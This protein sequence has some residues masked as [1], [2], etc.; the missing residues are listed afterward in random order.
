MVR[1]LAAV[2]AILAGTSFTQ[3]DETPPHPLPQA[4]S[5]NDYWRERPLLDALSH[6]FCSVEADIFLIDGQLLVGHDRD[7]LQPDRT[8]ETLYLQPLLQRMRQHNGRIYPDG[9]QFTLLIDIK[10]AAVETYDALHA[11]LSRYAPMLTTVDQGKAKQGA[12]EVVISGNRPLDHVGRQPVRYAGVDG[13]LQDLETQAPSHL[14]P[15]ISDNWRNVFTWRGEGVMPPDQRER[16]R[17]L[18]EQTYR[19]GRRLRF[20]GAPDNVAVWSELQRAGVDV[21]NTDNLAG[22][23]AFLR[24]R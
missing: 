17:R 5:H 24:S 13:R 9:P 14:V 12:V 1:S 4:H 10:S 7:E 22:L 21:I 15:M 8:L 11:E 18:V 16:L 3:A 6:G 23:A 19:G 20:W 2:L